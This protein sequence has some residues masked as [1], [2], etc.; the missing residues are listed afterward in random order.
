M[1]KLQ[2][3]KKKKENL[4]YLNK[5]FEGSVKIKNDVINGDYLTVVSEMSVQL[6]E[7]IINGGK[8]LIC[9]NGGSAADAQHLAAELLIRLRPKVNRKSVPAIALTMD[10]STFTA[11]GNDSGFD[12]IFERMVYSLG[13]PEDVL[14]GISTSGNSKNVNL[15]FQAAKEVGMKSFGF[16]GAGGGDALQ[17]CDLSFVVPSD[18]TGHIQEVHITAGHG[19]M[20]L[21]EDQ[22]LEIG[23]LA[24]QDKP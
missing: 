8:L 15:A 5:S 12:H 4:E 20:E 19:L 22:L 6:C 17:H 11:C 23:Y 16:L 9:G 18:S 21:V 13:K 7:S 24:L 1:N 10:S 2:A 14:L 3:E